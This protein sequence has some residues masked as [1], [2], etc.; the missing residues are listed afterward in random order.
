MSLY[1][2]ATSERERVRADA[3][4]ARATEQSRHEITKLALELLQQRHGAQHVVN[5]ENKQRATALVEGQ[6]SAADAE[7]AARHGQ[8]VTN[9]EAAKF[10]LF[11]EFDTRRVAWAG[12]T[13]ATALADEVAKHA[14]LVEATMAGK[15]REDNEAQKLLQR[16]I[17]NIQ[18]YNECVSTPTETKP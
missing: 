7:I 15:L 16:T 6:F 12:T 1:T 9:L 10:A 5:V 13:R 4:L 11:E 18:V 8:E 2:A 3:Q 17:H 14:A